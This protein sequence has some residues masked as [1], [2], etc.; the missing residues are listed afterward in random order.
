MSQRP[1]E[2][3][4]SI[5]PNAGEAM[6]RVQRGYHPAVV[7]ARAGQPLRITFRREETSPCSERVVFSDFEVTAVLPQG[8][9]VTIALRPA[10]PGEYEFTC[11]G[12]RCCVGRL[13]VVSNGQDP[14]GSP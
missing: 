8:Q 1:V 5:P 9:D 2:Q 13:V 12:Q 4:P 3:T 11:S 6:V 14:A 7:V 10:E